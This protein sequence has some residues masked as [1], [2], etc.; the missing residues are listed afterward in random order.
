MEFFFN[1]N[2]IVSYKCIF[3]FLGTEANTLK[4]TYGFKKEKFHI[5]DFLVAGFSYT[6]VAIDN[7]DISARIFHS[8]FENSSFSRMHV[9]V[10]CSS[11]MANSSLFSKSK[12]EPLSVRRASFCGQ[13]PRER[14]FD[15]RDA[16]HRAEIRERGEIGKNT[17]RAAFFHRART[18][19]KTVFSSRL[20]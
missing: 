4:K 14:S 19:V 10:V 1:I 15:F 7:Y 5:I 16:Q 2:R 12:Y 13:F 11:K 9:N 17:R 3:L 20:R 6:Y 8:L 18:T